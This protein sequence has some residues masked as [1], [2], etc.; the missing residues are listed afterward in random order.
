[1]EHEI[2]IHVWADIACP[3]CW[4][5]K[6]RL[7]KG[8]ELSGKN[9]AVEYHSY[10]LSPDA[11]SSS[12]L[13]AAEVLSQSKGRDIDTIHAMLDS[14][15]A[16]GRE[17]GVEFDFETVQSVN[18]FLAHQLVYAAKASGNTPEEAA[19]LGTEMF[20]RLYR[21]HFSEGRNI[22]D[23]DTLIEIAEELG[24]NAE[25]VEDVLESGEYTDAVR[26]DF[27]D[28]G[29]LG[30]QGVPFYVVGGKFGLSGAQPPEVFAETITRALDE[31]AREQSGPVEQAAQDAPTD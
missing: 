12:T 30:I 13:N 20:E 8:I 21:A 5:G 10:Q 14:V 6:K 2:V 26:S 24:M 16:T 31:M 29:T 18:T 3:W 7:E 4:I 15:T 23:G 9:V 11:P 28:A 22:A 17:V 1:M 25:D 27:R 19:L